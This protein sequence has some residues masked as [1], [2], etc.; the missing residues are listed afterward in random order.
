MRWCGE[1]DPILSRFHGLESSRC[2]EPGLSLVFL[3]A[4]T[5]DEAISLY[6][7]GVDNMKLNY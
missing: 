3:D 4:V 6:P 2:I 5:F 7:V 1:D